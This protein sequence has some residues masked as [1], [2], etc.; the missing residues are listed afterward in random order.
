M[1]EALSLKKK[2]LLYG[3]L[4]TMRFLSTSRKT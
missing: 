4:F 1:K 2:G 3:R